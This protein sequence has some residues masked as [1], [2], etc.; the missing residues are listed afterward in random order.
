MTTATTT[1]TITTTT[2]TASSAIQ[3]KPVKNKNNNCRNKCLRVCMPFT[4]SLVHIVREYL[5]AY[6]CVC[7]KWMRLYVCKGSTIQN[8]CV[9]KMLHISTCTHTLSLSLT[10]S[11]YWKQKYLLLFLCS[12]PKRN[13]TH[14]Q[15]KLAIVLNIPSNKKRQTDIT[16][17]YK[18]TKRWTFPGPGRQS[19]RH[20]FINK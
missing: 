15:S 11:H 12:D 14:A 18:Q 19:D 5:H 3:V 10:Y 16:R 2:T 6:G 9:N 7:V 17:K 4:R 1:S 20:W 8:D 13:Y